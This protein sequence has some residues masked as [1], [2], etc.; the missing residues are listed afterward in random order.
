MTTVG[1]YPINARPE[2]PACLRCGATA[3]VE[4]HDIST[5]GDIEPTVMPGLTTCPTPGCL[6]QLGR[7]IVPWPPAPGELTLEDRDW[8]DWQIA[9]T[10]HQPNS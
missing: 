7:S 9:L 3:L 2:P 5:L 6:D 1:G 10:K 8:V 4:W